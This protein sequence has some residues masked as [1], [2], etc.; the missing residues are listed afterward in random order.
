MAKLC[1]AEAAGRV[2]GSVSTENGKSVVVC[3]VVFV[4]GVNFLYLLL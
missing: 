4:T 1:V 3:Y 2:F